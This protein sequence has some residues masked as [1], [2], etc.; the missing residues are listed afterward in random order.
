LAAEPSHIYG[1]AQP[2]AHPRAPALLLAYT[3][4]LRELSRDPQT[5]RA[6]LSILSP[7]RYLPRNLRFRFDG[8]PYRYFYNPYNTTWTNER[9]VEVPLAAAFLRVAPPAETLEVGNVLSHYIECRW[10]VIDKFEKEPGVQNVDVLDF[11]P[12]RRYRLIVSISTLEHV[13]FDDDVRE[14]SRL[15]AAVES[16]LE[17]CLAKDGLLVATVPIG[18]NPHL[19]E[20][21]FGRDRLF[22]S[23]RYLKRESPLNTWRQVDEHQAALLEYGRPYP[24]ANGLVIATKSKT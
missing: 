18:Y 11:R 13:G 8:K 21:I 9:A 2:S 5:L 17:H 22:D 3:E 15:E 23:Q 14:P 16:L 19:D 20:L 6:V 7:R 4:W 10:D 1:R 12:V 24:Y